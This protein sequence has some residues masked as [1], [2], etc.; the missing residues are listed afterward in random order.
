MGFMASCLSCT[1]SNHRIIW[2]HSEMCLMLYR[3]KWSWSWRHRWMITVT[4]FK[5]LSQLL[6]Y[7]SSTS[8]LKANFGQGISSAATLMFQI[9]FLSWSWECCGIYQY[10]QYIWYSFGAKVFRFHI[11]SWR[12]WDSNPRPRAYRLR[13][14]ISSQNTKMI[15]KKA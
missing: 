2:L 15:R 8:T 1:R 7:I 9:C 10:N 12:E 5:S 11:E 3:I 14:I 4:E 6:F 13:V